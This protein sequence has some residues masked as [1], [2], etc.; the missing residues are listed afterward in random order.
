MVQTSRPSLKTY[1]QL[2]LRWKVRTGKA[3]ETKEAD[4]KE[5]TDGAS[6]QHWRLFFFF[7]WMDK[8]LL[9]FTKLALSKAWSIALL[10][11]QL[12]FVEYGLASLFLV[13]E[14]NLTDMWSVGLQERESSHK[15]IFL[16]SCT[17]SPYINLAWYHRL[18]DTT[19]N[20]SWSNLR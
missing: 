9:L 12:S 10:R 4:I 17:H 8:M 6:E 15:T 19:V 7:F 18:G 16:C 13:S 11:H 1:W 3:A 14:N 5:V 2:W 20:T